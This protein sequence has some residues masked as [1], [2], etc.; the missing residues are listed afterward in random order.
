MQDL[1]KICF[2]SGL[3]SFSRGI[4]CGAFRCTSSVDGQCAI[5]GKTDKEPFECR[6]KR[7]DQGQLSLLPCQTAAWAKSTLEVQPR[8]TAVCPPV[9]F[10]S[11]QDLRVVA[12]VS[13]FSQGYKKV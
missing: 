9:D 5:R 1:R 10:T 7:G 2:R 8:T 4:V 11:L 6:G 3:C 13:V 12:T